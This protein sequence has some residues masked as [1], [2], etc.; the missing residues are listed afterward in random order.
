MDERDDVA[1][2]LFVR[3]H[4]PVRN[5]PD[6]VFNRVLTVATE[7]DEGGGLTEVM[8]A[9][10]IRVVD[11]NLIVEENEGK[12]ITWVRTKCCRIKRSSGQRA[13]SPG[14]DIASRWSE[15]KATT[16]S[17]SEYSMR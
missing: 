1:A 5:A 13:N 16:R 17:S 11:D 4:T 7:P 2:Y 10:R 8:Q 6:D 15:M 14:D 3:R 12:S 9:T